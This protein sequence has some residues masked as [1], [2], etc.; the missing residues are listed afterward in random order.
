MGNLN[1]RRLAASVGGVIV[2]LA[3]SLVGVYMLSIELGLILTGL[4]VTGAFLY[5]V[6]LD[7]GDTS[8]EPR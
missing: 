5:L 2:G 8:D 6:R 4:A 1:K 7:P 3:T